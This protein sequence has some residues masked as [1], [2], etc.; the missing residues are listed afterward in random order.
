MKPQMIPYGFPN[1]PYNYHYDRRVNWLAWPWPEP[2]RTPLH[3]RIGDLLVR[4][5][6]KIA[7]PPP[8]WEPERSASK[9]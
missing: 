9:A 8:D 2:K 6:G 5:G 1:H 7:T 3:T 4:L